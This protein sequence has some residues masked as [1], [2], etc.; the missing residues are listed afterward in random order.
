LSQL[1]LLEVQAVRA[2][3]LELLHPLEVVVVL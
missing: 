2:V 3:L 1:A